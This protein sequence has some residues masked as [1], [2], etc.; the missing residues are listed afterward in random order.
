MRENWSVIWDLPD[1]PYGNVQHVAQNGLTEDEVE[2]VLLNRSLRIGISASSGRP[3]RR[4]H[5]TTGRYIVVIWEQIDKD[6]VR[7]VTAYEP[8]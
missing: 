4:G 8:S 3:M 7:P 6:T 2:D 1:D 5:T